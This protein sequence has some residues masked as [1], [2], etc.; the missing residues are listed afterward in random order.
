M[1]AIQY[2][3]AFLAALA[4]IA[5]SSMA[6][7][8][9]HEWGTF[10]SLVGSNGVTQ[11][12]MYHEDE[13]LPSF[14]HGFGEIQPPA[15]RPPEPGAGPVPDP[16]PAPVPEPRP[17]PPCRGKMCMDQ[18]FYN[19]NLIT[20]KMETPVIYFYSDTA[21]R[22]SVN[23]R[24]PEGVITET[25]PAPVRTS[26][27]RADVR[28]AKNGDTTFV[29]DVLKT[30]FAK[31]PAEDEGGIYYHARNTGSNVIASGR[32]REKFIFYR[33]L[34]R[35]QPRLSITSAGGAL[36][37]GARR[38]EDETPAAFLVDV[39]ARGDGRML[40]LGAVRAGT[41]V[42]VNA[43]E[44]GLLRSH[45]PFPRPGGTLRGIYAREALIASLIEA[46]LFRD[47]A[48]AM[49]DTWENGYLKVPGL[50]LLYVLPRR[51]VDQVLPL[52]MFPAPSRL[53]RAFVG[54]IEVLL[55]TD[56]EEIVASVL[57]ARDYFRISSLGRFAEPKLRRALEVYEIR[58]RRAGRT[59]AAESVALFNRLIN[60]AAEAE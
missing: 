15:I 10:T 51:E 40:R 47:E 46:G 4:L 2:K 35:F 29:V 55:D 32:E 14:V 7:Y 12:G 8:E 21:Q 49:V 30:T 28:E 45:E 52:T 38:V 60:Q 44:L 3:Q 5:Q 26:P 39:D 17:R 33:G 58:E 59:P 24:F 11:H 20:Q 16:A 25:Y 42:R 53:E 13:K 36:E 54:R 43:G 18:D 50:R 6:N 37:I 57:G 31:L 9:A 56:E 27:T 41:P 22:V 19:S 23:V 34:G 48:V 1:R